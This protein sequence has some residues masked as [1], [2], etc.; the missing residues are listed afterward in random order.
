MKKAWGRL[1]LIGFSC[2]GLCGCVKYHLGNGSNLSF[3]TLYISPVCNDSLAPQM[4]TILSAQVREKL[5]QHPRV[6]LVNNSDADAT[7]TINITYFGQSV[8]TFMSNDSVR[9]SSFTLNARANC[10]LLDNK[11]GK[12][13]F[14]GHTVE[15][16]MDSRAEGDY[17]SNKSQTIPQLSL[18]LAEKINDIVCN[19]W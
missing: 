15:A 2:L 19:P 4:Q 7:L 10:S 9:A 3:K 16:N 11:T 13:L 12:Y 5:S 8:A 6:K 18:K 17:Q 14:Q 1:L